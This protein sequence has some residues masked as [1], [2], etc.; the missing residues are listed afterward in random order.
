[1]QIFGG[2]PLYQA[3]K[4]HLTFAVRR[5]KTSFQFIVGENSPMLYKRITYT[6]STVGENSPMIL[7]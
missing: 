6:M 2:N 4:R 7:T 5:Y 3:T 1:M